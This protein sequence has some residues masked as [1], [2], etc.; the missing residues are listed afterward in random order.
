MQSYS[1]PDPII[2]ASYGPYSHAVVAGDFVFAAG[3]T[4]RDLT[5]GRLIE[6]GVAA[7]TTRALHLGR[8]MLGGMG[9]TLKDEGPVPGAYPAES[10]P[11]YP[12]RS[13]PQVRG[14]FDALVGIEATAFNGR[15]DRA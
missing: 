9:L 3:Q 6:A 5:T 14:P 4:A 12:A 8:D 2:P 10:M 1:F 11:P 7:P 13:T 15:G